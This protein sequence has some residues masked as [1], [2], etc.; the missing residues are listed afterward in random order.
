M[1]GSQRQPGQLPAWLL[2]GKESGK[3]GDRESIAIP[4]KNMAFWHFAV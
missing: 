1:P 4:H 2:A 3:Q